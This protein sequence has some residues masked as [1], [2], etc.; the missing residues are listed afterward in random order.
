METQ[1]GVTRGA[2]DPAYWNMV[3]PFGGWIASVLLGA[4]LDDPRRRG[5][6]ISTSTSFVGPIEPGAFT[7]RVRRLRENRS[8]DFW[9]SELTQEQDGEER[10]CAYATVA[11]AQRPRTLSHLQEPP[12][13]A[14]APETF[15]P[16]RPPL[17]LPWFDRYELLVGP[18]ETLR[19]GP[20]SRTL[21]WTRKHGHALDFRSLTEI[22]DTAVP[23]I[24]YLTGTPSPIAT[25][26]MNVF[27][28]ASADELAAVGTDYVLCDGRWRIAHDGYFDEQQ[29]VWSRS[30]RLLATT[31]QLVWYRVTDEARAA[32]ADNTERP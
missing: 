10:A 1:I 22:C 18:S 25:V 24:F 17:Q 5:D 26:T 8:T 15:V 32:S 16:R 7:L 23:R 19:T 29:L 11:L 6:P 27:F 20:P 4:V 13:E 14:G 3:G 2:T 21:S 28:H 12:P 30:G 31:E 9:W